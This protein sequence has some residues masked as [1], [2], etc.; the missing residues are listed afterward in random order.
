MRRERNFA[1][2]L[3]A[4]V[5]V[6]L[7]AFAL[8]SVVLPESFPFGQKSS[9]MSEARMFAAPSTEGGN[10]KSDE[11][12]AAPVSFS[13][14]EQANSSA[15]ATNASPEPSATPV[16]ANGGDK[17][18]DEKI[19]AA[20]FSPLTL[21]AAAEN[22][23][24]ETNLDWAFGGKAQRG[25]YLYE[26]LIQE[27]LAVQQAAGAPEFANAVGDFQQQ[28]GMTPDGILNDETLYKIVAFWQSRRLKNSDYPSAEN[29]LTAPV[30][31]FYD[32]TRA[33]ELKMV[34]RE[35]YAAYKR[36]VAA[37]A[38]DKTLNL[39]TTATG[40]LAPDEKFLKIVSAFR[41]REYQEKLRR[42]SPDSGRAG[43]AANSPHF[44]GRALD[45]YVGGEPVTT[46]DFNRAAQIQ[47]PVY[48]WL[49]K[50]AERFG[51][52]PYFYEPWH[53]EFI[54]ENLRKPPAK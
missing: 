34:E 26:P 38:K 50:N 46:K 33:P 45:L 39:K 54:P 16:S 31:D 11:R 10:N 15:E 21:R 44:T 20:A 14:V 48:K 28:N 30:A 49:V 25:W 37:A 19:A 52:R 40:E 47:T 5:T 9:V 27:T 1:V 23:R 6:F 17:R 35:T 36:M 18:T 4:S 2:S 3:G 43:L 32:P 53:W 12:R 29:L 41:S 13:S 8:S 51:F 24:L 22:A 42:E 7:A